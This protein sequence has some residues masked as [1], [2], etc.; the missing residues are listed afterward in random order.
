M[1][2]FLAI[3]WTN[4]IARFAFDTRSSITW[5]QLGPVLYL[6]VYLKRE[7]ALAQCPKIS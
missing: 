5:S 7:F 4:G 3:P 1:F 6:M 2:I